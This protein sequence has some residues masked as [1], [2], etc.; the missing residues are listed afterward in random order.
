MTKQQNKQNIRGGFLWIFDFGLGGSSD[1][2]GE[3]AK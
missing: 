2:P 1:Y 3:P